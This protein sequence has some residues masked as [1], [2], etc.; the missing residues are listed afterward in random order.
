MLVMA[1]RLIVRVGE[2]DLRLPLKEG[3]NLVGSDPQADVCIQHPTVSRK[4]AVIHVA[5]GGDDGRPVIELE[6][7]GSRNGTLA[8]GRKVTVRIG[9][10]PD[11]SLVFGR[12][13]ASIEAVADDDL[14]AAI[15]LH[16]PP[17]AAAAAAPAAADRDKMLSTVAMKPVD[18]FTL[19]RLPML[20]ARLQGGT[21]IGEMA[22]AI[23]SAIFE[24]LPCLSVHVTRLSQAA[25]AAAAG[26]GGGG[27]GI[28]YT[29]DRDVKRGPEASMV[30]ETVD[31]LRVSVL[32]PKASMA[33]TYRP[34]VQSG[35]ILLS[36]ARHKL[37]A[38]AEG[39][40]GTAAL[41]QETVPVPDPASVVRAV[42]RIYAEARKVAQG[43][44][45]VLIKGE[46]GTGKEVL[47]RFI[48]QAS[49]RAKGPFIPLNCAAL[50][51]DLLEL[52][53]FGIERGVATNVEA[54]PGKFE[55][56]NEGTLFLD[57][58][59][60]MALETQARILRVLQEGEVYRLG[61]REPRKAR[62]RVLAATNGDIEKMLSQASFRQDLY[63]RIATWVVELPPL[64][65]RSADIPNLAAHFLA[66][67]ARKR[68]I[69][70]AGISRAALEELQK[71]QWPGNIRQLENEVARAVLFM[72][73]GELLD[74][75]R[76]SPAIVG[77]ASASASSNAS[78][79]AT[80][81]N[82]VLE[83]VE[84]QE[85]QRALEQT[86]GNVAEAATRLQISLPTLYRRIKLLGIQN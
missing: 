76:L 28:L 63:H 3:Q 9:I 51:R 46:S 11:A 50:P 15:V 79:A 13:T 73:P 7:A 10:A 5:L 37:A 80:G 85:I 19:E 66:R 42:Q 43:E 45:S 77:S 78:A 29:A 82:G 21:A 26:A 22:Q 36:L 25:T 64:R 68:G 74:T 30:S 4:H 6:D 75:A 49:S 33:A 60:D 32:F 2:R 12:V 20:L 71:Y 35:V 39:A 8:N 17:A 40:A 38:S 27:E 59:A 31:D 41:L 58:I 56:A 62:V 67:E 57:E 72:D 70:A 83:K 81:L 55:L 48:H 16:H 53:L 23:G 44:I 34:V 24:S 65:L 18:A 84:R 61:G 86:G 52:E 1:F 47:A 54:R 69:Q 14:E